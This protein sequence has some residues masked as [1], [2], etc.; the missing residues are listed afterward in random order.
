MT[1]GALY[2]GADLW[3]DSTAI[4]KGWPFCVALLL[5]LGTHEFGHYIASR[6]HKV[7]STLPFFIPAPPIPPMIGTFGAVIRLKS[8]ITTKNALVDIGASGPL[9]GFVFA[10]VVMVVGINL[11][12]IVPLSSSVGTVSLGEPI[13]EKLIVYLTM[14]EIP[15]G[16]LLKLHPVAFAGWIGFFVTA[17]NLLPIGQLDGGHI[18]YAIFGSDHRKVT[19]GAVAILVVM[20]ISF[21]PGWIM[22][23]ILVTIIGTRHPPIRDQH[24]RME[25]ARQFVCMGSIFVF[26]LT[27][28][29]TPFYII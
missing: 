2:E 7:V 26:V 28:T 10:V 8:P 19:L 4:F 3:N 5:I 17:L 20:G 21:W 22:W 24:V 27:F 25:P 12:T 6:M 14:G 13:I 11:S 15:H 23:A 1:A 16:Y 9:V 29:P 18:M